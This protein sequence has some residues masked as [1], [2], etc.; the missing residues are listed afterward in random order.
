M[1]AAFEAL[2]ARLTVADIVHALELKPHGSDG[3]ACPR[4]GARAEFSEDATFGISMRC[5]GPCRLMTWAWPEHVM[6][7][8]RNLDLGDAE[9]RLLGVARQARSGRVQAD[10]RQ[11][12]GDRHAAAVDVFNAA[13][14]VSP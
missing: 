11:R 14:G 9:R 6:A 13:V 2:R 3:F 1:S 5:A 8:V 10:H 4:C 12:R 7:D